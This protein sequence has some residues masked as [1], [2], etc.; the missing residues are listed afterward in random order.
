[1]LA[2]DTKVNQ[3]V[4]A[5]PLRR[6]GYTVAIAENGE[7]ALAAMECESFD[8]VLM[9]VPM[10]RIQGLEATNVLRKREDDREKC[11]AAG[12]DGYL[13]KPLH[14]QAFFEALS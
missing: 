10:F 8:L 11:L 14:K 9:N 12:T 5:G 2:E 3:M 7:Q 6:G 4:A 13:S 1:M